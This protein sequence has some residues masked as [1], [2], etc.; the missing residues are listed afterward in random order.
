MKK[1]GLIGVVL[2]LAVAFLGYRALV[3]PKPEQQVSPTTPAL[4]MLSITSQAFAEG[5]AIPQRYTC[6]GVDVNPPLTIT[7][8]PPQAKSLVLIVDDPDAPVGTWNHWLVWSL[9]PQT[10]EV[11][12]NSVPASAVLGT[13][14]FGKLDWGGPCPPSG[15]HRY[16][17]RLFALDT[18]LTLPA[19]VKRAELEQAMAGHILDTGELMGRYSR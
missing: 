13:N 18:S 3:K 6:D 12:E 19:G 2:A 10:T 7:N 11:R 4:T 14:D 5:G 9:D 16:V 17:F 1:V 8:V 15:T